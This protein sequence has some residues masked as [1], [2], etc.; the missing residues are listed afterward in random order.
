MRNQYPPSA[1]P[2]GYGNGYSNG[3]NNGYNNGY[4]PRQ[5]APVDDYGMEYQQPTQPS[6]TPLRM[7]LQ[8]TNSNSKTPR[9]QEEP[10]RQS[11]LKRK[12]SRRQ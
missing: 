8:T 2:N 3:Y 9:V 12:L 11:W 6:V 4:A 1:M 7:T 5:T 10:K